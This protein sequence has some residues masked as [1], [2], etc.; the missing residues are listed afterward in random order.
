MFIAM[1]M[2]I[3]S[4]AEEMNMTGTELIFRISAHQ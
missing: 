4:L 3:L 2:F 1:I